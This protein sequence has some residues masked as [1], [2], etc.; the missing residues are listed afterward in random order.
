MTSGRLF[1]AVLAVLAGA[2]VSGCASYDP[3]DDRFEGYVKR[4]ETVTPTGGDALAV[5]EATQVI[6]P[7]PRYVHNTRIPGDGAKMVGAVECYEGVSS[8]TAKGSGTGC[9][10]GSQASTSGT[11]SAGTTSQ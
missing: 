9:A 4:I 10:K 5:N 7:W 8:G 2:M 6:D 11:S 3:I 1:G